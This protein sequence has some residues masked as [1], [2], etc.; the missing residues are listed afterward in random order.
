[1]N[2]APFFDAIGEPLT[3]ALGAA[4]VGLLFGFAAQRSRFCLRSAVI[5]VTGTASDNSRWHRLSLWVLVLGVA[6]AATQWLV[7]SGAVDLQNVRQ[8]TSARSISG[9]LIGGLLFGIGAVLTRGC[10]SRLTVLAAT[11]NMRAVFAMVVFAAAAFATFDGFLAPLRQQILGLWT[12]GADTNL[13]LLSANGVTATGGIFFGAG[14]ALVALMA[15]LVVGLGLVAV[16]SGLVLGVTIAAGWWLTYSLSGQVFEPI[17]IE[18]ISFTRPTI[19]TIVLG[20]SGFEVS[21]LGFGTGILGGVLA[22]SFI[23]ALLSGGLKFEWFSSLGHAARFTA[24][25]VLMGI[26]G[27]LAGGCSIGAGLT[28][29]SLAALAPLLALAAM[30]SGMAITDLALARTTRGT[31]VRPAQP[32]PAE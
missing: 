10:I 20:S 1:M 9:V 21:Q 5:D 6:M 30:I 18:S 22:G 25:A 8:F 12:L 13:N 2:F 27:V 32:Y 26:G 3:V 24:G 23:A 7:A 17:A 14:L 15:G 4:L 16:L 19:D 29:G 31:G 28:G 11:G